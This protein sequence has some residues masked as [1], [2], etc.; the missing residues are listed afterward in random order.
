MPTWTA[1]ERTSHHTTAASVL[2]YVHGDLFHY[3]L[4]L[5]CPLL[6]CVHRCL[7]HYSCLYNILFS[8]VP[9]D[10]YFIILV[11]TLSHFSYSSN[12]IYSNILSHK[13]YGEVSNRSLPTVVF[14]YIQSGVWK[15]TQEEIFLSSIMSCCQICPLMP[16]V[17]PCLQDR[18]GEE[19]EN[20]ISL[21]HVLESRICGSMGRF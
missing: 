7:F 18:E 21:C 1:L 4:S 10:I 2:L 9:N 11:S 3:F 8:H 6:S 17:L 5:Q 20:C 13:L 16:T 15:P 14:K 19:E 12:D